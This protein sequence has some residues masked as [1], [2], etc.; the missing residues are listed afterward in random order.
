MLQLVPV[1]V[2]KRLLVRP[3]ISRSDQL[4]SDVGYSCTEAMENSAANLSLL[5]L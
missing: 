2:V 3:F 5:W 1:M 4:S